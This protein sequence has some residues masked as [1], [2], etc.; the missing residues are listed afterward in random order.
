MQI[1]YKVEKKKIKKKHW[2]P[3]AKIMTDKEKKLK[4]IFY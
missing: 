1:L 4:E 3:S 2:F